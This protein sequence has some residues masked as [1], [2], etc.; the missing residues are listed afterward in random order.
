MD[1]QDQ[2]NLAFTKAQTRFLNAQAAQLEAQN[3]DRRKPARKMSDR[4]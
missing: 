2:A 4:K 3:A 1:K